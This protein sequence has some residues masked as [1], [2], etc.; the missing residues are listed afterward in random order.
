MNNPNERL[1]M[2][3]AWQPKGHGQYSFFVAAESEE[4]ARKAVEKHMEED[5]Y[6]GSYEIDGWQTDYY[7][8]T[9]LPVGVATS[10]A[11]D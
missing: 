3:Y 1:V 10:N 6:I 9:V 8:L 5:E 11:N 4:E 7:E 2:L